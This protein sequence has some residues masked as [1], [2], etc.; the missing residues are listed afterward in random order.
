MMPKTSCEDKVDWI[1]SRIPADIIEQVG[2]KL[3]PD[4]SACTVDRENRKTEAEELE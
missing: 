4:P 1:M 2:N 3:Q